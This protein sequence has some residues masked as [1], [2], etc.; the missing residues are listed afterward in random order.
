[1]VGGREEEESSHCGALWEKEVG[2][3]WSVQY[4]QEEK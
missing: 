2:V 1:M 4:G 3:I